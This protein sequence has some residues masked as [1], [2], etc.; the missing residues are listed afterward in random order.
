ME[1]FEK[2]LNR[3]ASLNLLKIKAAHTDLPTDVNPPT[4]KEIKMAIR[5]IKS[6]K[7]TGHDNIQAK[8]LKSNIEIKKG[9]LDKL[10]QIYGTTALE[11]GQIYVCTAIYL[12]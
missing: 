10:P 5:Q 4:T 3:P 8:T 7:A 12:S 11:N 1:Y 9:I 2:L 6:G